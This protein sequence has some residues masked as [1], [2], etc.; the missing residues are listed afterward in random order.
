GDDPERGLRLAEASGLRG[1][2]QIAGERK[3]AAAAEAV[4]GHRG[5]ER[6]PEVANHVP[7]LDAPRVVELDRRAPGE[8]P[9]VGSRRERALRPTKHDATDRIVAVEP[10]QFRYELVHQLVGKRIEL[11]RPIQEHDRDRLVALD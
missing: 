9:D 6:R 3:L 2:D 7:P 10:L 11:L 1:D 5:D 8:L 4:A